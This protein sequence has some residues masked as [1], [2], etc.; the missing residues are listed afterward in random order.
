MYNVLMNETQNPPRAYVVMR[1]DLKSLGSGK[2][3]AHAHHAGTKMVYEILNTGN[4]AQKIQLDIW[5]KQ[6]SGAGT[7]IVLQADE[8]TMKWVVHTVNVLSLQG[9][10]AGVWHDPTYP[11][12]T[13]RGFCVMP[14]D[15]CAWVLGD[16]DLLQP[17]LGDLSLMNNTPW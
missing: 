17:I 4:R 9:C 2:A 5:Q 15:V 7:C 1:N 10:A 16:P 11:S 6:A 8:E 13:E 14:M 12:T 3:S